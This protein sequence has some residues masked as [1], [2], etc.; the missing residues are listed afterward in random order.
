MLSDDKLIDQIK[1]G[2]ERAAEELITRYYASILRY[3]R[4]HCSSVEKA[5][6][7]TQEIFY[8]LFKNISIRE[9]ENLK[10]IY[11]PLQIECVLMKA[12][13]YIFAR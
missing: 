1:Y 10:P 7:L 8:K 13:R 2:N 11:T 9:K 3:C 12:E 4:W 6:D 5:E